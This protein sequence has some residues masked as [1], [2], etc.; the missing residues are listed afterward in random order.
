WLDELPE[1]SSVLM[2]MAGVTGY[3]LRVRPFGRTHYIKTNTSMQEFAQTLGRS[4]RHSLARRTRQLLSRH[5]C[6]FFQIETPEA[7]E[8]AL[9][10][11]VRLHQARWNSIG[12]PGSFALPGFG[13]FVREAARF[14]I[15]KHLLRLWVLKIDSRA[16]AVVLAFFYNGVAHYFQGGFDPAYS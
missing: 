16:A 4:T 8:A 1:S 2:F 11:L 12:Q 9:D 3:T 15:E 14:C 7:L 13:A 6:E 10:D 5:R